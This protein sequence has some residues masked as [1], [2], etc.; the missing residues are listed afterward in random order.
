MA[1][2]G[3]ARAKPSYSPGGTLAEHPGLFENKLWRR[4]TRPLQMPWFAVLVA[5]KPLEGFW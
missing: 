2:A 3:L 4:C 5:A 1:V